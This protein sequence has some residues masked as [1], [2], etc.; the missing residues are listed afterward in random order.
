MRC[1]KTK[2]RTSN[3]PQGP[4]CNT[5]VNKP[6]ALPWTSRKYPNCWCVHISEG[7]TIS[8]AYD[9]ITPAAITNEW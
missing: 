4:K 6:I 7:P 2:V 5:K 1:Y 3:L 9:A 8:T